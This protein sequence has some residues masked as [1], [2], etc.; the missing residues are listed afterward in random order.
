MKLL[1][2]RGDR[3]QGHGKVAQMRSVQRQPNDDD[4]TVEVEVVKLAVHVRKCHRVDVGRTRDFVALVPR[5]G[6][7]VP[8]VTLLGEQ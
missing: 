2:G 8:P 3:S 6:R 7:D 4:V 1:T 5:S